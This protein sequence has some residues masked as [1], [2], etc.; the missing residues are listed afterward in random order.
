MRHGTAWY[1]RM[2]P[3]RGNDI[4]QLLQLLAGCPFLGQLRRKQAAP[5]AAATRNRLRSCLAAASGA[6][7]H[8]GRALTL[9]TYRR[10]VLCHLER[11]IVE[12]AASHADSNCSRGFPAPPPAGSP[13][14]VPA[15]RCGPCSNSVGLSGV[16]SI[17]HAHM[18]TRADEPPWGLCTAAVNSKMYR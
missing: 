18:Q 10:A 11:D 15:C 12:A 9:I 2:A 3:A 17:S 5:G 6:A 8:L 14:R 16:A 13:R 1:Q 7:V 4:A